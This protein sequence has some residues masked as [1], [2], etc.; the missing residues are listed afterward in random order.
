MPALTPGSP[1]SIFISVG[2]DTPM[3]CAQE[4]KDSRLRSRA[5]ARSPPS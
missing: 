2:T 1:R 4:R 3:R 5:I